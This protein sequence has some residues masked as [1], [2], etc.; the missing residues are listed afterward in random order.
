[1]HAAAGARAA[2]RGRAA[3][4]RRARLLRPG[5]AG[6]PAPDSFLLAAE[7][8][9]A[10]PAA[11]LVLEDAPS[12]VA[13]GRAAGMTVWAVTTTHAAGELT[14][15]HRVADGLPAARPAPPAVSPV[16]QR[17]QVL[18]VAAL[19]E[20]LGQR[21]QLGVEMKPSRQAISSGEP[22]FRPWRSSITRTNSAACMSESNVPVSSHAVPRSS[23]PTRSLPR[24]R[25]ARLTSVISNSPR[26]LGST[27]R[28]ISTT[29]LS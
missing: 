20:R 24:R 29:S 28:A 3:G 5:R 9:G 17:E 8:L 19:H 1:M 21:A 4:P 22:I 26:A 15:A 7:R 16:E 6:K 25:Y 10:D 18:A 2:A 12:G 14:A 27:L 23:T 11:C 13:A